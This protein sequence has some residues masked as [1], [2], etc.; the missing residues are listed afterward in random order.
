MEFHMRRAAA[1]LLVTFLGLLGCKSTT[2][3]LASKQREQKPDPLLNSEQQSRF[4]R[5]RF[6]LPEDNPNVAPA[7]TAGIFDPTHR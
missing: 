7:T 2:G 4:V 3:P 5:E 1:L 6:P